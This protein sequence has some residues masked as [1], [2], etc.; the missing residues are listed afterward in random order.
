MSEVP[1]WSAINAGNMKRLILPDFVREVVI[2]ADNGRPGKKA[3]N[4]AAAIFHQEGHKVRIAYPPEGYG[5]F[6]DLLKV[7]GGVA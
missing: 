7:K 2:F 1:V 6:N 4:E 5:D 3:A